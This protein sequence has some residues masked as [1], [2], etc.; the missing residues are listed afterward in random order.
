MLLEFYGMKI[1]EKAL[2]KLLKSTPLH[3]TFWK[4]AASG[5]RE[6]D[7]EFLYSRKENL[8][9][10]KNLIVDRIP[11]IVSLNAKLLGSADHINH[12]IV[13]TGIDETNLIIHYPE[14]GGNLKIDNKIF[15]L[16]WN[17]RDNRLGYIKK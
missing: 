1:E 4:Y 13:V 9:F 2:R 8:E 6:F 14:I 11:V 17:D 15:E 5:L 12:V 3:G 7:V 16:A 10:L